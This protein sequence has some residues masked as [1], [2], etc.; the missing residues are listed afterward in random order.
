MKLKANKSPRYNYAVSSI[1]VLEC[2]M[3]DAPVVPV[4]GGAPLAAENLYE[5]NWEGF[6]RIL[7]GM[8]HHAVIYE[9]PESLPQA[10]ST[11]CRIVGNER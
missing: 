9:W 3:P 10:M 5:N 4:M 7:T 8:L 1:R 6:F 2:S 11:F